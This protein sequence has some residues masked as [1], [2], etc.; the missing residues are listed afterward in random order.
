MVKQVKL[1]TFAKL[2]DEAVIFYAENASTFQSLRLGGEVIN[3]QAL[4][5]GRKI[6]AGTNK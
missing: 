6:T 4:T 1:I 5:H 3:I 2:Y